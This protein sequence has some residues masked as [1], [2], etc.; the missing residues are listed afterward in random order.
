MPHSDGIPPFGS[1]GT[2]HAGDRRLA[3]QDRDRGTK[4]VGTFALALS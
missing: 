1:L 4:E 3:T 2:M